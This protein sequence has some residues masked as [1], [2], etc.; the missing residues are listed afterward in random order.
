MSELDIRLSSDMGSIG[1][2]MAYDGRESA[3]VPVF[4]Q[5][6][7]GSVVRFRA[8]IAGTLLLM[9]Q[10]GGPVEVT[11]AH[12]DDWAELARWLGGGW[13]SETETI[14][15]EANKAKAISPMRAFM[16][17]RVTAGT[18]IIRPVGMLTRGPSSLPKQQIP[19]ISQG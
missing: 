14:T 5:G 7:G 8:T 9:N 17:A 15:I 18:I 2:A 19:V 16:G 1:I 12:S 13:V 4:R 10:E 3:V 6:E 11:L